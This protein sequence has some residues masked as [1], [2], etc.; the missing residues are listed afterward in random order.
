M[1]INNIYFIYFGG[2]NEGIHCKEKE[3]TFSYY[4]LS[5][6]K[7]GSSYHHIPF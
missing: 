5:D 6:E 7:I 1:F 2:T 3:T 4:F